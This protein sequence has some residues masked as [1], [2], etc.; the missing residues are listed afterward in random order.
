ME[1]GSRPKRERSVLSTPFLGNVF[2]GLDV[3]S[4]PRVLAGTPGPDIPHELFHFDVITDGDEPYEHCRLCF[5]S[6]EIEQRIST[7]RNP[8]VVTAS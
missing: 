5:A 8:C 6:P 3:R 4:V 7:H 2:Q 1:Y